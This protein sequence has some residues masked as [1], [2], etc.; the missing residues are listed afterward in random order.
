MHTEVLKQA[1]GSGAGWRGYGPVRREVAWLVLLL[2]A[3]AMLAAGCAPRTAPWNPVSRELVLYHPTTVTVP[4]E[5]VPAGTL[6]VVVEGKGDVA[7]IRPRDILETRVFTAEG[8]VL[9]AQRL[10][11]TDRVYRFRYL[12]G[13]KSEQWGLEWRTAEYVLDTA[14]PDREY[15]Q[16]VLYLHRVGVVLPRMVKVRVLDRL[17][18]DFIL[19]RMVTLEYEPVPQETLEAKGIGSTGGT[20]AGVPPSAPEGSAASQ[21]VAYGHLKPVPPFSRM[22]DQ[23]LSQ[24]NRRISG[25]SFFWF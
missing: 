14:L 19:L 17:A 24:D 10:V 1:G 21:G 4:Q 25:D 22:Y 2:A 3:V 9:L 12:G 20:P 23:E 16:Y 18:S 7:T 15:E 13:M 5:Y 6:G 11:K 8:S